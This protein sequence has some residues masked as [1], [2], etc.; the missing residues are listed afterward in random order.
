MTDLT[1]ADHADQDVVAKAADENLTDAELDTV[2]G[3]FIA[4]TLAT[5]GVVGA[6]TAIGVV[7]GAVN[8]V[9]VGLTG[10]RS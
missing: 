3:G 8:A 6:V 9:Q 2:A 4:S 7:A 5:I 1:D 10:K